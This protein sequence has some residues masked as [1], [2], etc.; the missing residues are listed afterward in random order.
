MRKFILFILC[1]V[2]LAGLALWTCP[3]EFA[4]RWYGSRL[5][6]VTLSELSGSL[7]EGHAGNVHAFNRDLGALDWQ[8]SAWPLLRGEK[9][10]QLSLAGRDVTAHGNVT[11]TADDRLDIRDA[12][13]ELPADMLEPAIGVP[14]L[15]LLGRID[16]QLPHLRLH[17]VW[18]EDAQG[19]AVWRDA[20]V[21]GAA[22]ARLSDLSASFTA[23]SPG[24]IHGEV[25]DLG[26]PLEAV[27]A[28]ELALTGY[29]AQL[30]LAA[31]NNDPRV[32]EALQF[33]GQPQTDGSVA[34]QIAGHLL[35]AF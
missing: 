8:L 35:K 24:H 18:V 15:H 28:F 31:R 19:S 26:G 7:W 12:A 17:Q 34:L 3:A 27:G 23:P 1:L 6:P 14:N 25:H 9:V 13:I 22:Q 33:V 2:L 11:S 29:D 32:L 4:Y 21:S 5:G 30:R 20:A 16:I 10:A